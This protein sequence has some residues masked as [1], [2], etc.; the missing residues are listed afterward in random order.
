MLYASKSD[1]DLFDRRKRELAKYADPVDGIWIESETMHRKDQAKPRNP[2]IA[3][4]IIHEQSY[5]SQ[6]LWRA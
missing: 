2:T 3:A 5:H 4:E 6:R 1:G